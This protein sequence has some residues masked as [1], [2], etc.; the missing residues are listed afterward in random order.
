MVVT[1]GR[2]PRLA[3]VDETRVSVGRAGVAVVEE[4]GGTS[5][6]RAFLQHARNLAVLDDRGVGAVTLD[7]QLGQRLHA[8]LGVGRLKHSV[9]DDQLIGVL[10]RIQLECVTL[11]NGLLGDLLPVEIRGRLAN[12]N[13]GQTTVAIRRVMQTGNRDDVARHLAPDFALGNVSV[14]HDLVAQVNDVLRDASSRDR[15][16]GHRGL[17]RYYGEGQTTVGATCLIWTSASA[18]ATSTP[19]ILIQSSADAVTS[20]ACAPATSHSLPSIA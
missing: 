11:A 14:R 10:L 2:K 7:E 5:R 16:T 15:G 4:R 12:A 3:V 18:P 13:H 19:T 20:M 6:N 1:A 9:R 17:L 8:L